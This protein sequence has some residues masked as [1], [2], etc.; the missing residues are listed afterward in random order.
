MESQQSVECTMNS[1]SLYY[2]YGDEDVENFNGSVKRPSPSAP[3]Y[4][5][6]LQTNQLFSNPTFL[7]C[8]THNNPPADHLEFGRVTKKKWNTNGFCLWFKEI[9]WKIIKEVKIQS[10]QVNGYSCDNIPNCKKLIKAY[11]DKNYSAKYGFYIDHEGNVYGG[12]NLMCQKSAGELWVAVMVKDFQK[13][14]PACDALLNHF[15]QE[16]LT[17]GT[18]NKLVSEDFR[19]SYED[20]YCLQCRR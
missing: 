13:N 15:K 2:I 11:E 8:D 9:P 14:T 19:I 6:V 5:E 10:L 1:P 18:Q 20:P 16:V 17:Y 12:L 7:S 3:L 4:D